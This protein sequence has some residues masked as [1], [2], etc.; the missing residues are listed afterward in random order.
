MRDQHDLGKYG[1]YTEKN[2]HYESAKDI[3][4]S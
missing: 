3:Y 1:N 4:L 2:V